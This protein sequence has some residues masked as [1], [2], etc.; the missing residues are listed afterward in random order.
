M[1]GIYDYIKALALK[2]ETVNGPKEGDYKGKDGL[3]RCGVCHALK[4]TSLD[5]GGE[6]LHPFVPCD[7]KK[8]S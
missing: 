4:Q 7:C 2:S 5:C 3:W 6:N 1:E 8:R